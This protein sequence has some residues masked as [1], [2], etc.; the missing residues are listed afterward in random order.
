MQSA[1]GAARDSLPKDATVAGVGIDLVES[2]TFAGLHASGGNA[3]LDTGWTPDEQHDAAGSAERL[4]VRWA[5]KEAVMKAL[6]CGLGDLEPLDVE[7][8]SEADGA[9]RVVLH[10]TALARALAL[11][12]D[13]WHVSLCHEEGWA[14]AIVIAER[15][16]GADRQEGPKGAQDA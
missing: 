6:R 14:V 7:I 11:G 12:V 13:R 16:S 4:A 1:W 8:V 15:L 10:R 9:P 3:F 2:G 5:A